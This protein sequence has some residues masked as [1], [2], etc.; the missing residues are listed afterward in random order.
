MPIS[1]AFCRNSIRVNLFFIHCTS[2]SRS[3][4]PR[5]V[6]SVAG[7]KE[8]I[9]VAWRYRHSAIDSTAWKSSSVMSRFHKL[10]MWSFRLSAEVP[11]SGERCGDV[12]ISSLSSIRSMA[13][14]SMMRQMLIARRA[15]LPDISLPFVN[16]ERVKSWE[17]SRLNSSFWPSERCRV[18]IPPI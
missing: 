17:N 11:G 5:R 3:A 16:S 15:T 9:W 7:R 10:T 4:L 2:A 1:S 6:T 13:T 12:A 18:K 8:R 14:T